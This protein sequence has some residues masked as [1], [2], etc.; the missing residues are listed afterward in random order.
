MIGSRTESPE[1]K[2]SIDSLRETLPHSTL[3]TFEGHGWDGE[4]SS[5][6]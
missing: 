5:L 6:T 4:R 2:R 3:L 1:L